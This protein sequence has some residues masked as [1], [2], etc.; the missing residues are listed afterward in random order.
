MDAFRIAGISK[1]TAKRIDR[2]EGFTSN[3]SRTK[4][5]DGEAFLKR[6]TDDPLPEGRRLSTFDDP[7]EDDP[8]EDDPLPVDPQ[9]LET[10]MEVDSL[11]SSLVESTKLPKDGGSQAPSGGYG[12]SPMPLSHPAQTHETW[13][14]DNKHIAPNDPD[15]V[16]AERHAARYAVANRRLAEVRARQAGAGQGGRLK[17]GSKAW[18]RR[19]HQRRTQRSEP[20]SGWSFLGVVGR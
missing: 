8:H 9:G 16:A 15:L 13:S 5:P 19:A 12:E 17:P 1:A 7:L 10:Q 20:K 6:I 2:R 18:E 14:P 4:R 11:R 3:R